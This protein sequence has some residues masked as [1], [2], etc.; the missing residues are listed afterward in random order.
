[1]RAQWLR[2]T[3]SEM[4]LAFCNSSC[5]FVRYRATK[6]QVVLSVGWVTRRNAK[7]QT[8]KK[9][10]GVISSEACL[11][12]C[13]GTNSAR[14]SSDSD[15]SGP[16][17][18]NPPPREKN[19]CTASMFFALASKAKE[20]PSL[21]SNVMK[22]IKTWHNNIRFKPSYFLEGWNTSSDAGI[23]RLS[24]AIRDECCS[25]DWL[26]KC[27]ILLCSLAYWSPTWAVHY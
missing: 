11:L 20:R 1:M 15:V 27:S 3:L 13:L 22:S 25:A 2:T 7:K 12:W 10:A 26:I 8:H 5:A 21:P 16:L 24:V 19:R 18:Q 4:E 9:G 6:S 14:P 23:G 17:L